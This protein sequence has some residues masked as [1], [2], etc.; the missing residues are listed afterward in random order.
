M[1]QKCPKIFS[2]RKKILAYARMTKKIAGMTRMGAGMTNQGLSAMSSVLEF[3]LFMLR[4]HSFAS[5]A[6]IAFA[7]AIFSGGR[8]IA[9]MTLIA[10]A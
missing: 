5:S 10:S 3:I 4:V 1:F 9:F 7:S 6:S 2:L 8:F